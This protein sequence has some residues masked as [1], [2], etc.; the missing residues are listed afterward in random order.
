[1][2]YFKVSIMKTSIF[3]S[4]FIFFTG[5]LFFSACN[6][7]KAVTA[8]FMVFGECSMCKDRIEAAVQTEGVVS[9]TWS[10]ETQLLTLEYLPGLIEEA[11]I[12]RMI[13]DAGHDT[14]LERADDAVYRALPSCCKYTRENHN[15]EH[16]H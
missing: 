10:S 1:M 6:Q 9:A 5:M 13:A 15:G 12:H 8:E 14:E 3:V 7:D 4:F 11:E 16:A 2:L